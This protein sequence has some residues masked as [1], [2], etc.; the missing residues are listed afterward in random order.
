MP[1]H[2][3]DSPQLGGVLREREHGRK[4]VQAEPKGKYFKKKSGKTCQIVK[5]PHLSL[6]AAASAAC[7]LSIPLGGLAGGL[8]EEEEKEQVEDKGRTGA[9][10]CWGRCT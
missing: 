3:Q 1:L 10:A 8:L 6:A 4:I 5:V 7:F 9:D 2:R